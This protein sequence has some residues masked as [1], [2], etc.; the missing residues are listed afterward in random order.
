[1]VRRPDLPP[2]AQ[3][4]ADFLAAFAAGSTYEACSVLWVQQAT[5]GHA[6]KTALLSGCQALMLVLGVGESVKDRRAGLF[7]AA[8]YAIGAYAAMR[9]GGMP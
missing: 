7:F 3:T 2:W 6:V 1:V 8:G 9:H 4:A 5:M